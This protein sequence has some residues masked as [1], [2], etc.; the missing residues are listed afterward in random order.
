MGK[1]RIRKG[2]NHVSCHLC[3]S[4]GM[5]I[6]QQ[7][8]SLLFAVSGCRMLEQ[9]QCPGNCLH[10]SGKAFIT[11]PIDIAVAVLLKRSMSIIKTEID[12][13][14]LLAFANLLSSSPFRNRR[15]TVH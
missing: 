14:R 7:Y 10:H 12:F 3:H 15:L 8:Q 13:P 6:G 4:S 11:N 1:G 2:L 5:G 9:V